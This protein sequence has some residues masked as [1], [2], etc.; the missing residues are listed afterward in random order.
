MFQARYSAQISLALWALGSAPSFAAPLNPNDFASLGSLSLTQTV[1]DY[2]FD[3]GNGTPVLKA[4][5]GSV[6]YSG[7]VSGDIAVFNFDSVSIASQVTVRATGA[8]PLGLLS[9]SSIQ[10]NGNLNANGFNANNG[11]PGEG[12]AGGGRGGAAPFGAGEGI[13]GGIGKGGLPGF[14]DGGGFGGH[15]GNGFGDV[16]GIAYGDLHLKLEG[17]SG[18]G[19]SANLFGSVAGGGGGGAIELGALSSIDFGGGLL[20]ATGGDGSGGTALLGGGSS[21]GGLLLHAPT[22]S[23][24]GNTTVSADGGGAFGGGG[25]ILFLTDSGGLSGEITHLSVNPAPTGGAVAGVIEYGKLSAV[26]V[27]ASAWLMLSALTGYLG[28]RRKAA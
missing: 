10:L 9:L 13:G 12:G 5:D 2:L 16:G 19:A 6:L 1:G 14:G 21:G 22:I 23:F 7:V 26:P 8:L 17:G 15:G 27:P 18:G 4:P 24:T 28:L 20:T 3:T 11:T 25:R